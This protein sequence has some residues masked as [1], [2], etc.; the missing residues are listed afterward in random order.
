[1]SDDPVPGSKLRPATAVAHLG[2]D[3]K[4]HLGAVNTPVYRASTILFDSVADLEASERGEYP[5]I[6]YGLHGLPTVRDLQLAV[7]ALEGG[8]AA[9]AVPSGLAAITLALLATTRPGDHVLVTDSVYGPTRRFCDQQL[10]RLGVEA[11]YYDP[12]AGTAIERE[13]RP[14]TRVVFAESPGSLSFE[15]QDLPALAEVAHRRGALVLLDNTWATPL[16]FPAF[17][18]GADISVH[19]GTKYVGGHSDVL[20]GWVT[21][22]ERTFPEVYRLWTDMGITA[23][24]DDCFLALRG[25]RTLAVRLERHTQSALAI[26]RWL[27]TRPEVDEVIFPALEGSRGHALWRRDFS[28]ACGLF[29]VILKPVAK[30]RVDAMLN[31]LR[32]FRMGWSWGGFESLIIPARPERTRSATRWQA[33]GPYLR[34]H[35]GLEDS[36]D[37]IADLATGFE[38]LRQ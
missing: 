12:Q 31:G 15:V 5:G 13:I 23:S 6:T 32:L 37:L 33:P 8:H 16:G 4:Q 1:M 36:A 7:A 21:C 18:R 28:G 2:R 10:R 25:L 17:A 38:R 22:N 26:A 20:V 35:V 9:L 3:P 27:R 14:T 30:A 24:S 34:L 29:G 11:S 19:A